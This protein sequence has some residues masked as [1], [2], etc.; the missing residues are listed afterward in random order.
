[1]STARISLRIVVF[2]LAHGVWCRRRKAASAGLSAVL[3]SVYSGLYSK[4]V[5]SSAVALVEVGRFR[6]AVDYVQKVAKALYET[7]KEVFEHVKVSLQRPVELFV[8]A[9]TRALAWVDK[10]KAYLFL[11]AAVAVALATALSLWGMIELEKLAYAASAPFFAGR[12][13]TGGRAA[14]R[15]RALA[16]RYER[17]KDEK[18]INEVIN[19]PLKGERLYTAFLK[20]S[21]SR[22][23]LPPPLVELRRA[24]ARVEGEVEKDAAVVAALVL[25]KTLINNAGAYREWAELYKWAGGLVEKQEFTVA[26]DRI[27]EL[28]EAQMRLEGVTGRVLEELNRV[29]ALYSQSD[30]YKE[31]PDLLNKLKSLLEVDLGMAEGLAK[32]RSDELSKYSNANVATK[33]YAALLSIARDGIYGHAAILLMAEGALADIVL[34]TPTTMHRKAWNIAKMRGETIDPSY[35]H[36]EAKVMGIAGR[37]GKTMDLPHVKAAGW[38]DRAASVL[39]RFL[40]GYGEIDPQLLSG[41]GEVNFKFR[42]VEREVKKDGEK[43]RVERGFQVFRVYG[44]VE[45]PVG[46]LRIGDVAR[47]KISEEELRRFV[48][49]AKRTAPDLSGIKKI[50]QTLEWLNTDVSFTKR[51]IAG[52]TAYLWQLRWYLALFGEGRTGGAMAS[53]T[54]EGIK[55]IVTMLWRR[56]VLNRIIAE[57]GEELEPLLG[58]VVKSWR[59][60]V[61]AIDWSRV[62][63]KVEELAGTLKPWIGRE[64]TSD[65]ERERLVRR[66]LG[67]LALLVHFAEARR[68][69]DDSK[70]REER[71]KRLARAV[72]V[73]SG[74]RIA[75][76]HAE[77]LAQAI[78]YYAESRKESVKKRIESLAEEVGVSREEMWGIVEFVLSDMYCLARDCARD[79]V[80]RK[81]V[82]PALELVMLDKALNDNDE[83]KREEALLRFGE[84]YATAVAGDGYVGSGAIML[85]VGGELGGGAAL[86]RLATLYLLNR[87]LP[88]E[89]K[90]GVQTYARKGKKHLIY[91]ITAYGEDAAK[92]KRLLA[93]TAP[94][95]GGEYLSDKFNEFVK[96]A[97]VEVRLDNIRLTDGGNVAADLTLSEGGV[98]VKYNVY[99]LKKAIELQLVSADRGRV[100]LAARLL[101]LAGVSAEVKRKGDEDV[102]Y[103]RA[104]TDKLA[105]G[106]E[107]LR[108]ALAEI[109]EAARKSVG[110]EKARRWLEKLEKGRMLREGWPKYHVGLKEGALEV[111]YETTNSDNIAR[112]AQRLRDMGLKEGRHFSVKMPEGDK[113][114]YVSILK[115]GLGHAAWLSVCGKDEQQRRLAAEF[116]SYILEKAKEAGDNVYEKAKKIIEEGVSRGSLRLTDVREAEVEVGGGRYVVTVL[117]G[118]AEFDVSR[119]G[120]KLLKIRITAEVNGVRCDYEITFGRYVRNKAEGRAYASAKAPGGREADAERFAAVIKALTG[121]EPWI[122]RIGNKIIMICGRKHLEGFRRFAELADA[123]ERW[124]EETSR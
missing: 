56:E 116:I 64:G 29:L 27:R 44:G 94:S 25:Y 15:F 69:I 119:S 124:L 95:A 31:R 37:R 63:E 28:R 33:V 35:S 57:E 121:E 59:E 68:G 62:L 61:D 84:M 48:E 108:K 97:R 80:V 81:F 78:V 19:A 100:E 87:L 83:S 106:R 16:E 17:W 103:V 122:Y 40:V 10:H 58:R 2:K 75:G 5:V 34:S 118:G 6:E 105:A 60:L 71:A 47:F 73:L 18:V 79:E 70:W 93:V 39:L 4:A 88:D 72:E 49:G 7:A 104:T 3:Y 66:M 82:A 86:L 54:E 112:E 21:E 26:A 13:K 43:K 14:E 89:L 23:G 99:L 1:M 67:E 107:E 12:T 65:A 8:E 111:R 9:V 24:L 52:S 114:G 115:E 110:E 50:W 98:A 32:A 101:R 102:W 46:E 53:V 41:A 42:L 117:G 113:M 91:N 30:F 120:K 45:A 74:G 92:F 90:F 77:R 36:K 20:L 85:V 38:E 109:V 123:I 96:E 11:M 51:Q 22:R 76:E 55:P